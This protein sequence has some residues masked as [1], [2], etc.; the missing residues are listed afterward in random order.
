MVRPSVDSHFP[1]TQRRKRS[2][3]PVGLLGGELYSAA[4]FP[5]RVETP[6]PRDEWARD[7]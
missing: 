3:R 6:S 1:V 5:E 4:A 7:Q 2:K